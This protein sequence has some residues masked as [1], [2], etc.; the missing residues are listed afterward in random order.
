MPQVIE[1]NGSI[2]EEWAMLAFFLTSLTVMALNLQ[3]RSDRHLNFPEIICLSW[4][5]DQLIKGRHGQSNAP[6]TCRQH[7]RSVR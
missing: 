5:I 3:V 4:L 6:L 7:P 2:N 1:N